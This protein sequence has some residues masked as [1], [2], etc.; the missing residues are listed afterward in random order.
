MDF[1]AK[2]VS[3]KLFE[4]V[5]YIS[6]RTTKLGIEDRNAQG[7]QEGLAPFAKYGEKERSGRCILLQLLGDIHNKGK[8]IHYRGQQ[9]HDR[10]RTAGK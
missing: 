5:V 2:T 9:E 1:L 6:L 3:G 7:S 4:K 10:Q 8:E